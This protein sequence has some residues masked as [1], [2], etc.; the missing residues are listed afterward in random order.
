MFRRHLLSYT[1]WHRAAR[2]G[3]IRVGLRGDAARALLANILFF[4][5]DE[6]L[7]QSI[8]Q[9]VFEFVSRVPVSRLTFMPDSRVWELIG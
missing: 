3:S 9:S 2:I 5:E 4:A 1:C 8:F 6:E 7:V